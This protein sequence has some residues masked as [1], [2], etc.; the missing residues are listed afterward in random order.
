MTFQQITEQYFTELKK[1]VAIGVSSGEATHELSYRTSLDN[2]FKR[3]ASIID[4]KIA[5]I[6]EPKNQ[7]KIG[8]PDWRFHNNE[9][10]GV[11]GYIEAKGLDPNNPIN[12]SGYQS[13]IE[14][15]LILEN[16]VILTDGIDFVLF[17]Q[18]GKRQFFSLCEKPI[19][20]ANPELNGA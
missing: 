18:D 15:Y 20:W 8:R 5:T 12:I 1:E 3:I 9:S 19:S 13:Q 10:M 4:I 7:G 11:Y 16:P 6:P 14:R 17:T 2:F